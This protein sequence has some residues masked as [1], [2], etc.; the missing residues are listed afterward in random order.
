MSEIDEALEQLIREAQGVL[1]TPQ[2]IT[3]LAALV[4][5]HRL[6]EV[7]DALGEIR[8]TLDCSERRDR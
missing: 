1:K 7:L 5:N 2:T 3:A 6:R 4:I 8:R